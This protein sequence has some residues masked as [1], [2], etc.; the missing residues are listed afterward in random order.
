MNKRFQSASPWVAWLLIF[1]GCGP[2]GPDVVDLHGRITKGGQPVSHVVVQLFPKQG[3][4]SACRTDAD[5]RYAPEFSQ[6]IAKGV[7]PGKSRV[8]IQVVQERIDE[9][10]NLSDPKF[11]PDTA[12]I[13]QAFGS[14]KDSPLVIDVSHDQPEVNIELDDYWPSSPEVEK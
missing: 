8:S 4:P 3:R 6:D 1:A 5:G 11:H 13:V 2:Q 10:I 14:W 9:P 12:A 7:L